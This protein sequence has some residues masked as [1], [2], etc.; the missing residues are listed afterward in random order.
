M[1]A[2]SADQFRAVL[3]HEMGH[4]SGNH[5]R[6]GSWIYRVRQVWGQL[7]ERLEIQKRRGSWFFLR[8]FRWFAPL[9]SAYS[10]VLARR[11]EYEADE[12]GAE[13][14]SPEVM[15]TALIATSVHHRN[16]D[17]NVW[18]CIDRDAREQPEPPR[19]L[20]FA[21]GGRLRSRPGRA[22]GP[23]LARRN[24]GG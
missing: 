8:F 19:E 13:M 2:L 21:A 1:L 10:F 14:T 20:F 23:P 11:H 3:A 17:E 24:A 7:V 18:A 22:P 5:G 15:A 16:L 6:F 12:C 9:F 4:F